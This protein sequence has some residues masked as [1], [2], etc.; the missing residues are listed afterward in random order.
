MP[1]M[2]TS[3]VECSQW[4]EEWTGKL[5]CRTVPSRKGVAMGTVPGLFGL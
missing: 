4:L 2:L 5:L 3:M 1:P